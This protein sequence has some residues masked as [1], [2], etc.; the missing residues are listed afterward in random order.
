MSGWILR[1]TS[2]FSLNSGLDCFSLAYSP[3]GG[4]GESFFSLQ[5]AGQLYAVLAALPP[6]AAAEPKL[7]H[8]ANLA[9]Y[10]TPEDDVS[11]LLLF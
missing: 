4:G 5:R 2:F 3:G 6:A 7:A 9:R 8:H 1:Y 10:I 11:L